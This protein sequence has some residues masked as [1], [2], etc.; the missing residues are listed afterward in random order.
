MSPAQVNGMKASKA[1][2]PHGDGV[3]PQRILALRLAFY[4]KTDDVHKTNEVGESAG[5]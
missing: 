1:V 4:G 2:T 3:P 5:D